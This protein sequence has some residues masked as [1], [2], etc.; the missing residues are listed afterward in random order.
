MNK[1]LLGSILD[2]SNT[3]GVIIIKEK[4]KGNKTVQQYDINWSKRVL[5]KEALTQMKTKIRIKLFKAKT[6]LKVKFSIW[7]LLYTFFISKLNSL[8]GVTGIHNI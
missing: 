5:G 8:S 6:K 4:I 3:Q 1:T 2:T 7:I